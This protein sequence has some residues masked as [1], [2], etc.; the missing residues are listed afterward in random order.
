MWQFFHLLYHRYTSAVETTLVTPIAMHPLRILLFCKNLIFLC[1]KWALV[2][3]K[4][5]FIFIYKYFSVNIFIIDAWWQPLAAENMLQFRK[6]K[7]PLKSVIVDGL[8]NTCFLSVTTVCLK[9][10]TWKNLIHGLVYNNQKPWGWGQWTNDSNK[11][12]SPVIETL[13]TSILPL[14]F[15]E[16]P[17]DIGDGGVTFLFGKY[18]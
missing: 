14:S 13:S 9:V 2:L 8:H 16:Q 11:G 7:R 3:K 1:K 10:F 6:Y 17:R 18:N 12:L 4:T 5:G 15:R